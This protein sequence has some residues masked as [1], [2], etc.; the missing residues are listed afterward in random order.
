MAEFLAMILPFLIVLAVMYF[1]MIR[2]QQRQQRQLLEMRESLKVGDEIITAGGIVG[3]LTKVTDDYI[4]VETADSTKIEL[5]K[6]SIASKITTRQE[7]LEN[8]E[9]ELVEEEKRSRSCWIEMKMKFGPYAQ[10]FSN[11]EELIWTSGLQKI[12]GRITLK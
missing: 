10:I 12:T 4:I 1:L 6:T 9:D 5:L 3:K 8:K 11:I 2:P 7:L